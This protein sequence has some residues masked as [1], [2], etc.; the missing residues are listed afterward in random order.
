MQ[1]AREVGALL[2]LKRRELMLQRLVARLHRLQPFGHLVDGATEPH[3]LERTARGDAHVIV[4]RA[5]AQKGRGE[6]RQRAQRRADGQ[7]HEGGPGQHRGGQCGHEADEFAPDRADVVAEHRP[8]LD[9][10]VAAHGRGETDALKRKHE[11][12]PEPRRRGPGGERSRAEHDGAAR[13]AQE[14]L[15]VAVSV[16]GG[17]QAAQVVRSALRRGQ[18]LQPSRDGLARARQRRDE[19]FLQRLLRAPPG[20]RD[21]RQGARQ[22]HQDDRQHGPEAERHPQGLPSRARPRQGRRAI[23]KFSHESRELTA[24]PRA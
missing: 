11:R 3:E 19:F 12:I 7:P 22:K 23:G 15:D 17:H 5:D 2:L 21:A 14:R 24:W 1:I 18:V 20:H 6:V 16:E 8:K 13:I 10:A 4:A 9:L